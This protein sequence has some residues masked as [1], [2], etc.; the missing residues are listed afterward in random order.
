MKTFGIVFFLILLISCDD[1]DNLI[2]NEIIEED[3]ILA[4][5]FNG[6]F[7]RNDTS[8]SVELNFANNSFEDWGESE[9]FPANCAGDYSI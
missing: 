2:V 4:G 9:K 5:K 7:H 8:A 3:E 6:E 1:N